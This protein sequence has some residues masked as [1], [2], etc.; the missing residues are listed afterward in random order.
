LGFQIWGIREIWGIGERNSG[1]VWVLGYLG[2][3]VWGDKSFGPP[4][5]HLRS[6]KRLKRRR[7]DHWGPG[8]ASLAVLGSILLRVSGVCV[9]VCMC[10]CV[11]VCVC[12]REK[13]SSFQDLVQAEFR[14]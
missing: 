6:I 1:Y 10:V 5:Y 13:A 3:R 4:E 9:S 12:E 8:D 11:S 2:L 7:G 14:V